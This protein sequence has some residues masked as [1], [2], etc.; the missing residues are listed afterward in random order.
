MMGREGKSEGNGIRVGV[1]VILMNKSLENIER[2]RKVDKERIKRI[3]KKNDVLG[4]GKSRKEREMMVK[5]EDEMWGGI[6]RRK[7]GD[8]IEIEKDLEWSGIIDEE[9][10]FNESGFER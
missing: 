3:M 4:E 10:D 1:K 2:E 7:G 6:L 5:N 8:V 9:K